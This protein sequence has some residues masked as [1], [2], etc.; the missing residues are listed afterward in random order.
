MESSTLA[1][2]VPTADASSH[3]AGARGLTVLEVLAVFVRRWHLLVGVPVAG[4]VVMFGLSYL[5]PRSYVAVLSF[6]PGATGSVAVPASLGGLASQFG[7]RL[8]SSDAAESPDFYRSL[9]RTRDVLDSALVTGYATSGGAADSAA[10]LDMLRIRGKSQAVRL[11]RG[12]RELLDRLVVPIERETGI[13]R[14]RVEMPTPELAALVA[15]RLFQELKA[16]N[17]RTRRSGV[18]A[19]REFLENRVVQARHD[20][21]DSEETLRVF[22]QRNRLY[23]DSPELV[24]EFGRLNRAVQQRQEVYLTLSREYE[25]SRIEEIDDTP[26][27]TLVQEAQPPVR[28]NWPRRILLAIAVA[29]ASLTVV[30]IS[31]AG[32]LYR[33]RLR[34]EQPH[35]Y[36]NLADA[37]REAR[38]RIPSFSR[39]SD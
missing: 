8:G 16:F 28:K 26:V 35:V 24:F 34:E 7:I 12:R 39:R 15:N 10:L 9:V 18:R 38:R 36:A 20:L 25:T 3:T 14:L 30:V 19:R 2:S 29:A 13:V 17:L 4:A 22:L 31:I 5:I 1:P 23:R 11:D 32:R 27:L 6:V 21:T 33:S 37:L